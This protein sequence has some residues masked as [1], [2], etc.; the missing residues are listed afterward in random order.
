M[1]THIGFV[2]FKDAQ[3]R[4]KERELEVGRA[5]R[6]LTASLGG[7]ILS[8]YW[9]PGDPDLVIAFEGRDEAQAIR[10]FKAL[11]SQQNV[12]VRMIRGLTEGEKERAIQGKAV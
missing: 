1:P 10:V 11:E 4:G 9:T 6:S 7:R 3:V 8:I 2:R 5:A 12:T